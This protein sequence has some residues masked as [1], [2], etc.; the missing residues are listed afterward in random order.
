MPKGFKSPP[1]CNV[2]EQ[3]QGTQSRDNIEK[4]ELKAAQCR[5]KNNKLQV[6]TLWGKE[7]KRAVE[8]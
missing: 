7:R 4:E 8:G 2:T 1:H 5:G 3:L 6:C